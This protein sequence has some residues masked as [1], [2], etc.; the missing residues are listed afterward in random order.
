MTG[1]ALIS[2]GLLGASRIA[3]TAVITP[4]R[5]NPHFVVSSVAARDPERARAYAAEHGIPHVAEDYAALVRRDDV[6]V[7]YNGLPPA[8]HKSWTIAALESGKAVLC[9]KP[10]ARN[11][12]EAREM[13]AAAQAAGSLL[14]EAF[15]YRFHN[16]MRA[17]VALAHE[18]ALGE[19]RTLEAIFEVAIPR[20]PD[21]L[22][23]S[24]EQ[25]GGALMDLG[26]YTVHAVRSVTGAEP[27]V[28]SAEGVFEGGVD[29]SMRAILK[30]PTGATAA[31]ACSM[32]VA[33]P[34]AILTV[35][36]SRGTMEIVNFLAPQLGCRF[37]TVIDGDERR[38]GVEGPTTYAAQLSHLRE[39]M[40]GK[41]APLTGGA[42]AVAN[43]AAIDAIYAAA[44]RPR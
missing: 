9:E 31:I 14:L 37:T 36:G 38:H 29:A 28:V 10:F 19:L 8:G 21:E 20:A 17:A 13:A 22:R 1:E 44:G 35:V 7:I 40:A 30:F 4:A 24:A 2:I 26:T 6:D 18:G 23:W 25:G 32:T 16:V 41:V 33:A 12:A 39:V 42:D 43:M 5:E 15:H 3:R 34:R 27:E 11:A